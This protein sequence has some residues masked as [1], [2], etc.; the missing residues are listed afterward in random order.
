MGLLE[1]AN[2]F[3]DHH[4]SLQ[5]FFEFVGRHMLFF[6]FLH[7]VLLVALFSVNYRALAGHFHRMKKKTL[8]FLLMILLLG[9]YLRLTLSS[10]WASSEPFTYETQAACLSATEKRESQFCASAIY[11]GDHPLGW[12]IILSIVYSVFHVKIFTG[13]I[14]ALIFSVM[15]ILLM[16]FTTYANCENEKL[17]LIASLVLAI[18]P[19]H[20]AYSAQPS[21]EFMN[22]FFLLLTLF[23]LSVAVKQ[24]S[25]KIYSLFF[26]LIVYCSQIRVDNIILVIPFLA[27]FAFSIRRTLNRELGRI[28]ILLLSCGF[29]LLIPIYIS[30]HTQMHIMTADSFYHNVSRYI[31]PFKELFSP[32]LPI[33]IMAAI[34]LFWLVVFRK[35]CC[36]LP[37]VCFL[38]LSYFLT[39]MIF[40]FAKNV[41][42]YSYMYAH[43]SSFL[44]MVLAIGLFYFYE[45]ILN[46]LSL[47]TK[48]DLGEFVFL[49][50]CILLFLTLFL[51][52]QA[53]GTTGIDVRSSYNLKD[54]NFANILYFSKDTKI[55]SLED[56]TEVAS[57]LRKDDYIIFPYQGYSYELLLPNFDNRFIEFPRD[58]GLNY[59]EASIRLREILPRIE[60]ALAQNRVFLLEG[61]GNQPYKLDLVCYNFLERNFDARFRFSYGTVDVIELR[62]RD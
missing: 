59:S 40:V 14:V 5:I 7:L 8:I 54:L 37:L 56:A 33:I 60:D 29:F 1:L 35:N 52:K 32:L 30:V 18:F 3:I 38:L 36:F 39:Q 17:S 34:G 48:Q 4:T 57:Q 62:L 2:S 50:L 21:S 44:V 42:M 53:V 55:K 26:L 16:F 61:R 24:K 46:L 15:T 45:A 11:G 13:A 49:V 12:P 58:C 47:Y 9:T 25:V 23:V 43:T 19:M 41:G 27:Y 22:E 51:A 20:I 28:V 31:V 10:A 6:T